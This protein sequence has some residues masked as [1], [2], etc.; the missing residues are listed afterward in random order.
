MAQ[1]LFQFQVR[2]NASTVVKPGSLLDAF[3][4]RPF[5]EDASE[6]TRVDLGLLNIP[7]CILHRLLTMVRFIYLYIYFL[8]VYFNIQ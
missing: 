8:F 2:E 3:S 1:A 7:G 4:M 6:V 5:Y